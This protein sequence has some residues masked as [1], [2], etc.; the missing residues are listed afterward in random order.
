M[1][2]GAIVFRDI[3]EAIGRNLDAPA[4]SLTPDEAAGHF[5]GMLFATSGD[6]AAP[7]ALTQQRLGWH[8]S[9]PTL[10]ADLAVMLLKPA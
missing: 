9:G 4:R 1:A 8:P 7:S 5:G 2:E 10:F 3:A 6:M